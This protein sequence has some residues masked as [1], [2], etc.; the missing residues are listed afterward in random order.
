VEP[1]SRHIRK[2]GELISNSEYSSYG[3]HKNTKKRAT[4]SEATRFIVLVFLNGKQITWNFTFS[5]S[6]AI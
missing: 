6:C 2:A 5:E 1:Y 4:V 3:D